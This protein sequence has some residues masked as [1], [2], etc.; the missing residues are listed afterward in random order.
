MGTRVDLL[1]ETFAR[2]YA[3]L[4]L[5]TSTADGEPGGVFDEGEIPGDR[6]L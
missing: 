2:F 1:D 5:G 3:D 4:L 6:P